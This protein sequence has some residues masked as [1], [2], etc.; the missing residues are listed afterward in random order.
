MEARSPLSRRRVLG[1]AAGAGAAAMLAGAGT[2]AL[3]PPAGSEVGR[4]DEFMAVPARVTAVDGATVAAQAID[5]GQEPVEPWAAVPVAGYPWGLVPRVGDHVS[6]TDGLPDLA[7]AAVPLCSWAK[8]VPA[9][10]DGAYLVDGRKTVPVAAILGDPAPALADAVT[11]GRRVAVALGD[12]DLAD[13]LVLQVRDPEPP[14]AGST[15]A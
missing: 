9:A 3:T 14:P 11:T 7:L 6:I 1:L 13:A 4:S 10:G 12:T 15:G 5:P 8:G 2:V